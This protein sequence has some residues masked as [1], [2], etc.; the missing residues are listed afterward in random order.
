[1]TTENDAVKTVIADAKAKADAF[2]PTSL[3]AQ[4]HHPLLGSNLLGLALT[5]AK[6]QADVAALDVE[7]RALP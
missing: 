5:L 4:Q 1:M 6:L 7:A 3:M 2:D